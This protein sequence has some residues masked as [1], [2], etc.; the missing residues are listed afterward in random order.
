MG[1]EWKLERIRDSE[2]GTER[3][4]EGRRE[5]ERERGRRECGVS[6]KIVLVEIE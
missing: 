1:G 5:G 2:G 6:V 3:G 4:L